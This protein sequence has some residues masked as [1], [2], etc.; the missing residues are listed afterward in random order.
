M[1][2]VLTVRLDPAIKSQGSA[3][4]ERLGTTPSKAVRELFDFRC[5]QR[6]ASL[7]RCACSVW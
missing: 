6:R 5:A 2:A 4:M 3:V 7:R 1:D